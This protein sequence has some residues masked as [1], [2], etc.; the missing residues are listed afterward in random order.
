MADLPYNEY[1]PI[2]DKP[3]GRAAAVTPNDSADL[4]VAANRLYIGVAGDVTCIP[5]GQAGSVL[6]KAAPV[7]ILNVSVSRVL[8]TGTTATNILALN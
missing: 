7:G 8:A 5:V 2:R 1:S 6:F 4:P 3:A